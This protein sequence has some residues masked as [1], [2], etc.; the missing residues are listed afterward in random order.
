ME[1]TSWKE[2]SIAVVDVETTGLNSAS[3]RVIEVG[4]VHMRAG[5]VLERWG[6]LVNPGIPIPR[7]VRD[8]TGIQQEDVEQAPTFGEIAEIVVTRL[9]GFLFVA[10]NLSFDRSFI[11][12][13]LRRCQMELPSEP[14]LDPLVFARA[15]LPWLRSKRLADVA[16]E[17]KID[18]REA[19]RAK[20]DA[21]AAGRVLFALAPRLPDDLNTLLT[22]QKNWEREQEQAFALRRGKE[23]SLSGLDLGQAS[24]G[25]IALGPAYIYGD[26]VDPYR[27]LLRALPDARTK[28]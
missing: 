14:G 6:S 17:L 22:L 5:E 21:E 27:A 23:P 13:E 3:D 10:Y 19:H 25:V 7:T 4:I 16:A 26:E 20:Q 28:S 11:I 9:T 15:Q 2:M 18:L 24:H 1:E 8:I 12:E